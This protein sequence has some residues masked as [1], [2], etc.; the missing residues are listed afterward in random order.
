MKKRFSSPS[1]YKFILFKFPSYF[2]NGLVLKQ[3]ISI[4][5]LLFFQI[6][7]QKDYA[8]GVQVGYLTSL[9]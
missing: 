4:F 1:K 6:C 2:S 3:F 7:H 8:A 9:C 5:F